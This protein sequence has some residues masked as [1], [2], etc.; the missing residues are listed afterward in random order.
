M[1][2]YGSS[3]M[4]MRSVEGILGMLAA[5]SVGVIAGAAGAQNVSEV[6]VE[7]TRIVA[8]KVVGPSSS[9]VP[10]TDV[11]ISYDVSAA[12][13]DLASR[14][15]IME[16]QKRVKDAA[17][18]ACKELSTRYPAGTPNEMECV[19]AAVEKAMAKVTAG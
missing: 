16:L 18:S 10:V 6:T 15:G 5:A 7:G 14:A 8:G 1:K 4:K 9:T 2:I 12:G 19:K 13:L 3:T 17:E 11:S